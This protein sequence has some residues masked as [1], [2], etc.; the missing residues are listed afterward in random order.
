MALFIR[1]TSWFTIAPATCSVFANFLQDVGLRVAYVGPNSINDV[2]LNVQDM[3]LLF[4]K[5]LAC[6][7]VQFAK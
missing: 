5:T 6:L 2:V 3:F 7:K 4:F 1:G